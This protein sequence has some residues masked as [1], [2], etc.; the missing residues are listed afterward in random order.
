MSENGL[1]ADGVDAAPDNNARNDYERI[2]IYTSQPRNGE[3][4]RWSAN[5]TIEGMEARIEKIPRPQ[6]QNPAAGRPSVSRI[7]SNRV[8]CVCLRANSRPPKSN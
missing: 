4:R 8:L 6:Q 2:A 5:R 7:V 1:A 3:N